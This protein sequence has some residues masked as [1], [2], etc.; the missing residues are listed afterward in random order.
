MPLAPGTAAQAGTPRASNASAR[1]A[2]AVPTRS[3][4]N[5]LNERTLGLVMVL[6]A[7]LMMTVV[8]AYPVLNAF[9]MSLH[10]Y[11]IKVPEDYAFVGLDNF[12][13]ILA[14]AHWWE[15]VGTTVI[16][17]IVSV[18]IEFGLGLAMA[19]VMNKAFGNW[20]G[21]IRVA[22][23]VPWATITVVTGL[24]WKWIFTPGLSPDGV[25]FVLAPFLGE[26]ACMLCSRISS[27]MAMVF[28]DVW[29]TA[30]FI[31]LLILAGL[32]TIDKEMY[33]AADVD[34][35][36]T[37]QKFIRITLPCLKPAILVALLFRTLDSFR[38]FDLAYIMT[39]GA[40]R[41]EPV[42]MIA[43][44]HLIK[45]LNMGLGSAMSVLIFLMVLGIAFFFTKVLGANTKQEA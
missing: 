12:T 15:A 6:P 40:N 4:L 36:T 3:L 41:T 31:A 32:Q 14:S 2:G 37:K 34:G 33:E 16:F 7:L 35:A 10:R 25:G 19:L 22:I 9:W 42:S 43:Y 23:L 38:M 8:A 29:K 30:P 24:A 39:G 28:A 18:T 27:I 11:S 17:T 13:R 26:D 44:D 5:K 20:T 21:V 1:T 45:R